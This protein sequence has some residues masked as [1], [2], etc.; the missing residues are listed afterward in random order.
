MLI[1][2]DR[3]GGGDPE[4]PEI[5]LRNKWT[6]PNIQMSNSDLYANN[7]I[8]NSLF[9]NQK[10]VWIARIFFVTSLDFC[11]HDKIDLTFWNQNSLEFS[12]L[13]VTMPR[14]SKGWLSKIL[15]LEYRV[16]SFQSCGIWWHTWLVIKSWIKFILSQN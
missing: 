13:G 4:R 15:I 6:V 9:D 11:E 2:C 12:L 8:L 7:I 10:N 3:G 1:H 14:H 5:V 16:L